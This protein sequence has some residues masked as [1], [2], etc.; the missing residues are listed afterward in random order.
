VADDLHGDAAV[1]IRSAQC[2]D[3]A[4]GTAYP[5]RLAVRLALDDAAARNDPGPVAITRAHPML[6]LEMFG[7]TGDVLRK[8]VV[9]VGEVIGMHH[10]RAPFV[11][12]DGFLVVSAGCAF[13]AQAQ[14]RA[15]FQV[16]VPELVAGPPQGLTQPVFTQPQ[17]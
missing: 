4:F 14:D 2:T 11:R 12:G 10:G 13:G 8:R 1:A 15:V 5:Q 6:D 7:M 9:E 3:V 17:L 16:P